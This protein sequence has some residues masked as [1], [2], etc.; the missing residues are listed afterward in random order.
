[1]D[2]TL[3]FK[4]RPISRRIQDCLMELEQLGHFIGFASARPFRD[5]LPILDE[6][7]HQHLLIGAN[8]AMAYYEG[9]PLYFN[10]IPTSL[11]LEIIE[12]LNDYQADYLIDDTLNYAVQTK[13][14]HPLLMNIAQ[15]S[16]AQQVELDQINSFVKIVVLSCSHFKELSERISELDVTI[17]YHSAEGILD[18]TY[19]NV[20]KMTGMQQTGLQLSP[21]ICMGNDMNDL[22]L[23]QQAQ[24]SVLI[25]EYEPL[26]RIASHQIPVDD[27]VEYQIIDKLQE[28]GRMFVSQSSPVKIG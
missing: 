27:R 23:F 6:R 3:S 11:A 10:S 18:I 15:S 2:G 1:M 9:K 21:F 4:G 13:Q 25:G 5:M 17:H 20:N 14:E 26:R 19:K 7:F 28:L 24:Y 8:G 12:I 22:P 16:L